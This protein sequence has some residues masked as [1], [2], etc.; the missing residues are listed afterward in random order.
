MGSM[1]AVKGMLSTKADI[2]AAT[3]MI[4]L[5]A[6]IKSPLE[7]S[8]IQSAIKAS[9]PLSSTAPTIIKRKMKN[10]SVG[11]S[12]SF[13]KISIIFTFCLRMAMVSSTEAPIRA[14]TLT[15]MCQ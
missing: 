13:S 2:M 7:S 15:S 1:V 4:R 10:I 6:A 9:R 14:A 3:Q 11:H 8:R 5:Q 12:I